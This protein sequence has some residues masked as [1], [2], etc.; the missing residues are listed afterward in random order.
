MCVSV[1]LYKCDVPHAYRYRHCVCSVCLHLD[2]SGQHLR[3]VFLCKCFVVVV[4]VVVVF[5]LQKHLCAPDAVN[6]HYFVRNF[7]RARY[8]Y[9][10]SFTH[11]HKLYSQVVNGLVY[12]VGDVQRHG[13]LLL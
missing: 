1:R 11:R 8:T 3:V 6:M 5:S 13:S 4:V 9:F 10:H 7:L 12:L 2:F